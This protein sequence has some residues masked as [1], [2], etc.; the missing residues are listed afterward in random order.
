MVISLKIKGYAIMDT[1][2]N[3][4]AYKE[5]VDFRIYNVWNKDYRTVLASSQKLPFHLCLVCGYKGVPLV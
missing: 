4:P 5:W 1:L 2:V 3:F